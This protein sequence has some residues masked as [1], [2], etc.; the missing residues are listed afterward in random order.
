MI[1]RVADQA[2]GERDAERQSRRRHQCRA[3]APTHQREQGHQR[4]GSD[5]PDDSEMRAREHHRGGP[6]R[7]PEISARHGSGPHQQLGRTRDQQQGD[8]RT[9]P[10]A[11]PT[12]E[13]RE[14]RGKDGGRHG[15]TAD[16]GGESQEAGP[17][18]E[19]GQGEVRLHGAPA[20]GPSAPG[21]FDPEREA[22]LRPMSVPRHGAPHH[23]VGAGR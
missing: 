8:R 12:P 20:A 11:E 22:A 13:R 7:D 21:S 19:E 14:T 18:R 4:T 9:A 17:A 3:A 5:G 16:E 2:R 10:G 1:G 6:E 23:L 15:E